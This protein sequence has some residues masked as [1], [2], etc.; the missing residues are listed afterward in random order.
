M[1][2]PMAPAERIAVLTKKSWR[3]ICA[4]LTP[5]RDSVKFAR[6]PPRMAGAGPIRKRWPLI[7]T[8]SVS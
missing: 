5:A 7:T 6:N 1:E 3:A 8:F 4:Q 2:N